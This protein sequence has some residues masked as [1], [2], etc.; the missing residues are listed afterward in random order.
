[1]KDNGWTESNQPLMSNR[2]EFELEPFKDITPKEFDLLEELRTSC[3]KVSGIGTEI[4]I[5]H[6]YDNENID[7]F[8]LLKDCK[9]RAITIT[10][11]RPDHSVARK[12][13]YSVKEKATVCLS[14]LD[15]SK[16][17]PVSIMVAFQL[18]T[19]DE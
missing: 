7:F 1:M 5:A 4:V 6:F 18:E 2:F 11:Y 10:Q 19:F 14:P 17:E 9:F 3:W 16:T 12:L 8:R 15:W 13:T